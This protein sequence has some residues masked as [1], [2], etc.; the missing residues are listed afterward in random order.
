MALLKLKDVEIYY[1]LHGKGEALILIAG[2]ACDHVFWSAMLEELSRHFQILIFDNRAVG[3]TK[4]SGASFTL[5]T[6]ADDTIQL[7]QK[8]GLG[9]PHILGQSMGG[10]IAQIIA[11]KYPDEINKLMILN[12]AAKFN[13]RTLKAIESL[14]ML[15]KENISLDSLVAA[16]LPW[17]FSIDFMHDPENIAAY[18]EA[19]LNNPYPQSIQDQERQLKALQLFNSKPWLR[20]IKNPTQV[21]A[22]EDD[23]ICLLTESQQLA[24]SIANAELK[25]VAGAHASPLEQSVEVCRIVKD[26][27]NKEI[28]V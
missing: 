20:T 11:H 23:I 18:K 8:L 1:E 4:D 24:A 14:I 5:E 28:M 22:A 16:S 25:I 3:Q 26:F 6:M 2:H 17:F 7:A 12:S 15:R 21:I 13:A 19:A 9:R 27:V 10:A